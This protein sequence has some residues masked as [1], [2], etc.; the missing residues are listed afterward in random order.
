M[1]ATAE[2]SHQFPFQFKCRKQKSEQVSRQ[3][4]HLSPLFSDIKL[5]PQIPLL[6]EANVP[7]HLIIVEIGA[8]ESPLAAR[9]SGNPHIYYFNHSLGADSECFSVVWV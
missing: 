4:P 7:L 8:T 6:P 2:E 1:A 3:M 5:F 9:E